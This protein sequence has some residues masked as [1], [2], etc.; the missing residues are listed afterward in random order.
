MNDDIVDVVETIDMWVGI[1]KHPAML[2]KEERI[3]VMCSQGTA[4]LP[5]AEIRKALKWMMEYCDI[6]IHNLDGNFSY[7]RCECSECITNL[8]KVVGYEKEIC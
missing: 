2:T 8:G 5:E 7:K 4:F 6:A 3:E 1:S